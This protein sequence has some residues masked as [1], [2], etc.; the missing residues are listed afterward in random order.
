MS[1]ARQAMGGLTMDETSVRAQLREVQNA[2][3]VNEQEHEVLMS[4]LAGLEG[5]LRL[6]RRNTNASGMT[7]VSSPEGHEDDVDPNRPS[8]R[9]AVLAV[10]QESPGQPIHTAELV[11]RVA[12]KGARSN[13][14]D[15]KGITDLNVLS[16]M[17]HHPEIQKV[18]PR[19]W[20][21]MPNGK[22]SESDKPVLKAV[23]GK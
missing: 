6:P 16:L 7:S 23:G 4:L 18:A 14:K 3:K 1:S 2:L 20:T 17:K 5:W 19:T 15:V 10:L 22:V 21:W 9:K 13:A 11:K 8:Y 12:D